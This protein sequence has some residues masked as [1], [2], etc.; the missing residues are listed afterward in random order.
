[1]ETMDAMDAMDEDSNA[2]DYLQD[3]EM[4]GDRLPQPYRMIDRVLNELLDSVWENIE[5]RELCLQKERAKFKI[6]ESNPGSI[7][8][9]DVLTSVEGGVCKG[10]EVVFVGSGKTLFVVKSVA[11]IITKYDFQHQVNGLV[12]VSANESADLVVVQLETGE[13]YKARIVLDPV[14]YSLFCT[15]VRV[16]GFL[17]NHFVEMAEFPH[18]VSD[19]LP[20]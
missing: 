17:H 19:A 9:E 7:V 5:H 13:G 20:A 4:W 1:M 18:Q 11:E 15:D 6:P 8:C 3:P 16:L 12:V 2:G 10:R 14:Y